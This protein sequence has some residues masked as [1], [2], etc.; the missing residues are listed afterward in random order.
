MR[1]ERYINFMSRKSTMKYRPRIYTTITAIVAAF[2]MVVFFYTSVVAAE[3]DCNVEKQ[4]ATDSSNVVLEQAFGGVSPGDL[5]AGVALIERVYQQGTLPVIVRLRESD[6]PQ[7]FAPDSV[8]ARGAMLGDIQSLVLDDVS[9]QTARNETE[10]HAK[11]FSTIPA[12]A[13]HVDAAGLEALLANPD[14]VEIVEDIPLE[15]SLQDS[16]ELIGGEMDGSFETYT[17]QGQTIAI[18][19]TGVDKNHPF[20]SGKVVS[21]ACYSTN[22][23]DKGVSSLCP[24][25]AASSTAVNSGL[26]CDPDIFLCGHGTN[27]AGVAAGSSNKFSGVA[28]DASII[29]IQVYS[30]F[31]DC[32]DYSSPCLKAYSSDVISGL[33][34]VYS[35]RNTYAIASVNMSLGSGQYESVCN[36]SIYKPVIDTLRAV[37]IATVVASGNGSSTTGISSPACVASSVSVGST[38]KSDA[39]SSFSNSAD[40]LSLLAPGSSITTSMPGTTYGAQS[41]TSIA[42]PHV[43]GA[44][45]VLKQAKP[46]ASVAEVLAALQSTGELVTDTRSGAGSR[47]TPRI[48][49]QYALSVLNEC[50]DNADCDDGVFCNG[51]ERCLNVTCVAGAV[52]CA[53]DMLCDEDLS[54]CTLP[55]CERDEDCFEDEICSRN[56]CA[57]QVVSELMITYKAPVAEKLKKDKKLKLKITGGEGFDPY[58][59][60]SVGTFSVLKKK[61]KVKYKKGVLVKNE[62]QV[63]VLIPAGY[64]K[65]TVEVRMTSFAGLIEIL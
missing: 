35:L 26:N 63:T 57:E 4:A 27:V 6:L 42:A 8:K 41:G 36:S 46:D 65:G 13:L 14:V 54:E 24:G 12:M 44:W 3:R 21:E 60:I 39:V 20:L 40:M 2:S 56:M 9:A 48:D 23:E 55:E 58:G 33:E 7:G 22:K 37:G 45:A 47:V 59:D 15:P 11:R 19:D 28:K 43:A 29:A 50:S 16:V 32:G 10:L 18:I 62:L 64:P 5:K 38:T 25:G 34:R 31:S 17:G 1:F 30:R 61:P 49:V 52:P 51:A 53:A